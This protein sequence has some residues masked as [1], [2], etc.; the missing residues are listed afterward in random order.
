MRGEAGTDVGIYAK[1]TCRCTLRLV[2]KGLVAFGLA[3]IFYEAYIG[4]VV[5]C[6]FVTEYA[7]YPVG[8]RALTN[9]GSKGTTPHLGSLIA[10]HHYAW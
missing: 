9:Y 8:W 5:S 6:R 4:I 2:L 3:K 1:W 10:W 7:L